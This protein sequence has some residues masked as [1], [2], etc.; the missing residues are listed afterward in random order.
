[1]TTQKPETLTHTS[2][3]KLNVGDYLLPHPEKNMAG[4]PVNAVFATERELVKLMYHLHQSEG[5][6]A[7]GFDYG[8]KIAVLMSEKAFQDQS[9]KSSFAYTVSSKTFTRVANTPEW[10]SNKNVQIQSVQKII[11]EDVLKNKDICIFTV[12]TRD[13]MTEV[14]AELQELKWEGMSCLFH[15]R[16]REGVTCKTPK[17]TAVSIYPNLSNLLRKGGR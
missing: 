5:I 6:C 13:K 10:T 14:M 17:N 8:R 15:L 16:N 12:P 3:V 2:A 1:M 7:V 4:E 11:M 9:K